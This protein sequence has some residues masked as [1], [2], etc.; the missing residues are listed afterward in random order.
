ME[1][2]LPPDPKSAKYSALPLD[3]TKIVNEVFKSNFDSNLKAFTK[4][5]HGKSYFDV[6][7]QI[8]ANEV[9]IH[10]SLITEGQI[11]ATTVTASCDFDPKASAPTV[12]D[13]LG[14]A[15]DT[16]G[17]LFQDLMDET[18]PKR[19]GQLADKSLSALENAPLDWTMFKL[20]RY[21]VYLK[22]DKSNPHLERLTEAWL[23]KN[24]PEYEARK[25][26]EAEETEKL[27]VTGK[28]K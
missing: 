15:V 7:G 3:Y 28:K 13:L 10:V 17:S 8:Y 23:E 5:A 2:R 16:V 11:A 18:N 19:L 1:R 22:V 14:A 20:D 12:E 9:V 21:K 4:V 6:S 24:D 25:A 27:F 26:R